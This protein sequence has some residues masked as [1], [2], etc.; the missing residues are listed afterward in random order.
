MSEKTFS[1]ETAA[2]H[3]LACCTTCGQLS[4]M[5]NS[6]IA[7]ACPRCKSPLNFRKPRAI[8]RSWAY[9]ISA[10]LLFGP[11]MMLPIMETGS[12]FGEQRDTIM[13]GII[14]LFKSGSWALAIIVFVASIFVP[15]AKLICLTYL[16][17]T[18]GRRKT[19]QRLYR[20][21]LYRI[22]EFVGRW[23]MLDVYVVTLLS[24]LVQLKGLANIHPMPGAMA[25]GAVV[26]LTMMATLSFDPRLIW[27]AASERPKNT[28]DLK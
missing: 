9:L 13:S 12:L 16:L 27:D 4:Q 3:G 24:V 10:Y 11:A 15:L 7:V 22:L 28:P 21:R 17:I 25:F 14:F 18:I 8:E 1:P 20:T 6:S 26:V 5:P 23:S 2:A 19:T